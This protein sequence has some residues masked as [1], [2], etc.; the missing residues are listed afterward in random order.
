MRRGVRGQGA[1]VIQ[2]GNGYRFGGPGKWGRGMQS[3]LTWIIAKY[4]LKPS[5]GPL[6]VITPLSNGK[7][8]KSRL[9]TWL[10]PYPPAERFLIT[11]K[12]RSVLFKT[13]LRAKILHHEECIQICFLFPFFFF[14]IRRPSLSLNLLNQASQEW[15]GLCTITEVA[16]F[17]YHL[18]ES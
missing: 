6:S 1:A 15:T 10:N 9:E 3:R 16:N 17:S 5:L 13:W 12:S 8:I 4:L 11:R 2:E 18:G 7:V 14:L